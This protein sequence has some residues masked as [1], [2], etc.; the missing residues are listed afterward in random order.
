M[1]TGHKAHN[2]TLDPEPPTAP[3]PSDPIRRDLTTTRAVEST[4]GKQSDPAFVP[5]DLQEGPQQK[6][7]E[8]QTDEFKTKVREAGFPTGNATTDDVFLQAAYKLT[9]GK[10]P[11]EGETKAPE[12]H[13]VPVIQKQG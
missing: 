11:V 7:E 2:P 4:P 8:W 9:G 1:P 10:I 3:Q 6:L 5:S 12:P 13:S